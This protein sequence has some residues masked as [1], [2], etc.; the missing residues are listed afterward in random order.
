MGLFD[1]VLGA[2]QSLIRNEAALDYEFL[3][4]LIPFREK[5]QRYMANCIKPLFGDRS[6]RN[7]LIYGP[8][9]IGKSAAVRHVLRDLEEETDDVHTIYINCWKYNTS[10]K[11]LTEVCENLGYRFTQNKKTTELFKVATQLLNKKPAV[12]VFDEIDKAEDFD[13]LYSFIEDIYHKA[14]FLLTN[15]KSWLLELDERIRSRLVAEL[16]EFKEYNESETRG[17]LQ[18]R[19]DYA[20]VPGVWDIE[21]FELVVS[22]TARIKDI[23]SGLFLLKESSLLAEEKAGTKI[24]SD[25]VTRAIAKLDEFSVKNSDELD[26]ESKFI[27]NVV[28]VNSG[29]KIGDLFED[30]QKTGGKASYKTFQRRLNKL[31]EG[32]FVKLTKQTGAGGN[33]TIVERKLT[34][35]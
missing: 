9:G 27:N 21:A 20:F 35:F 10:Y 16:Q 1:N 2:D 34:D 25:H 32:R 23:R 3:P 24:T 33:T 4:K 15:Y 29:K 26:E 6:G 19:V 5:E 22:R 18:E 7:I 14:I 13:F 12:L 30:Y 17:I 8:P 31:E 11:I 28:K